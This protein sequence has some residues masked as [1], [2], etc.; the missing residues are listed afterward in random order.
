MQKKQS[1]Y[2]PRRETEQY[3]EQTRRIQLGRGVTASLLVAAVV[4]L[5]MEKAKFTKLTNVNNLKK[6]N[7]ELAL[8]ALVVGRVFAVRYESR[9]R[10]Y[11]LE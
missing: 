7:S 5:V 4:V 10:A 8:H 1:L 6:P 9:P 3:P 2:V 11:G